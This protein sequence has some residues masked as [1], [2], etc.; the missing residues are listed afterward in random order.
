MPQT[1]VARITCPSCQNQFQMPL[2]QIVDVRANPSAKGRVLNGLINVAACPHC[3]T[4]GPLDMPF[5]YH[6]PDKELALIYMPIGAGQDNLQRQQAIGEFTRGVMDS[7]PPEERKAYLFQPQE[8]IS[9]EN[10][11]KKILEVEGITPEMI[12]AQRAK[13]ELLGKMAEAESEE[14]LQALIAE[15]EESIDDEFFHLL[16]VNLQIAQA[17]GRGPDPEKLVALQGKLLETTSAGQAIKARSEA[18]ETLREDPSTE[19]LLDLLV[20]APDEETREVLVVFGRPL[21]DYAFFQGLTSRI[22]AADG[23]EKKRLTAIRKEVLDTRDR[24]DEEGRA[25]LDERAALLRDLMVSSNPENLARRR[26]A[27]LDR[28]FLGVLTAQ[29]EEAHQAGNEDAIKALQGI[30]DLVLRLTEE[31]LPPHLRLLNRLLSA[32]DEEAIDKLL[33]ANRS[34]LTDAFAQVLEQT[35][36]GAQEDEDAP[37]ETVERLKLV[38][39]KVKAMVQGSAD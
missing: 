26:L 10:L 12:E 35:V 4:A 36:A 25:V 17:G 33:E 39:P 38:L 15:N 2:E 29:L 32:E 23:E 37:P 7:L 3:G 14:A 27:E 30:W 24:L 16:S 18:V 5:M 28:T 1:M 19:K 13:V 11:I 22:E 6:D 20:Q 34:L 8:F 31:T 21:L 9:L